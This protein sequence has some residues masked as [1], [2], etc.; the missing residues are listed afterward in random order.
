[1]ST[2][3]ITADFKGEWSCL[4]E[5]LWQWDYGQVLNITGI[6]DLPSNFVAHCANRW[7][8]SSQTVLGSNGRIS[9]PNDLL[10]SGEQV[11]VWIVL[12]VDGTDGETK[13]KITIPVNRRAAPTDYPTT[14][15][16][17]A[18][19]QAI[20]ALNT[21]AADAAEEV[22][23]DIVDDTLSVSGKAADAAVTGQILNSLLGY[24]TLILDN[25][26]LRPLQY[27]VL[28]SDLSI[29]FDAPSD[30]IHT[31]A[32]TSLIPLPETTD[33]KLTHNGSGAGT[34]RAVVFYD[35]DKVEI[36]GAENS[37]TNMVETAIP[38]N[39]KYFRLSTY[40]NIQDYPFMV[41]MQVSLSE[42]IQYLLELMRLEQDRYIYDFE[43]KDA[44]VFP[45]TEINPS[46][47]IATY[48]SISNYSA[49]DFIQ[50]PDNISPSIIG[51]YAYT[52]TDHARVAF[53]DAQK[54]FIS[55]SGSTAKRLAQFTIPNDA[56]F[57][58][59]GTHSTIPPES[60]LAVALV[61]V[62]SSSEDIID[63]IR[64][65]LVDD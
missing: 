12:T 40:S 6:D 16:Q 26:F 27:A 53:Y 52:A 39:A 51:S 30:Y 2:N 35:S 37:T 24:E 54:Q 47:G 21:A 46:T 62:T 56:V 48:N 29:K 3:I 5:P 8:G 42:R 1:M 19:T 32:V 58:R 23:A 49:T 28:K 15:Q 55:G 10:T 61:E 50:L 14:E 18:I 25:N 57:V 4:T 44:F 64:R 33:G 60:C 22:A 36:S 9:I 45:H 34:F 38:A 63:I 43:V 17:S 11:Y 65:A 13:Y 20:N 7:D 41:S 31:F 59:F